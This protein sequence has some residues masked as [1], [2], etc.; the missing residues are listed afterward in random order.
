M[1]LLRSQ[2]WY[3]TH[4]HN[5]QWNCK[6]P[7][8]W[9][10]MA[11]ERFPTWDRNCGICCREKFG[12][13]TTSFRSNR[14]WKHSWWRGERNSLLGQVFVD[15][16]PW[17]C[18]GRWW[19]LVVLRGSWIAWWL[20]SVRL[21]VLNGMVYRFYWF[22]FVFNTVFTYFC[23]ICWMIVMHSR[24]RGAYLVSFADAVVK[25]FIIIIIIIIIRR[26]SWLPTMVET[27][28]YTHLK[29]PTKA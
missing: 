18:V 4:N 17:C 14:T 28:S 24:A 29:L 6:K 22:L 27:V 26:E 10:V 21:I 9:T 23:D 3:N 8:R 19:K 5:E 2:L 25:P 13:N 15:V 20:W 7:E 16:R 12:N 1:L 11:I